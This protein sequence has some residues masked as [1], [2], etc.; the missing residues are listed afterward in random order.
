MLRTHLL[1]VTLAAALAVAAAGCKTAAPTTGTPQ[2]GAQAG[3]GAPAGNGAAPARSAAEAGRLQASAA[4]TAAAMGEEREMDTYEA[5]ADEAAAAAYALAYVGAP[6]P[7]PG[8][9]VATAIGKGGK[10]GAGTGPAARVVV[11]RPVP[12]KQLDARAELQAALKAKLDA[13]RTRLTQR[14]HGRVAELQERAV[15]AGAFG[16]NGWV[17][18]EAAGTETRTASFEVS[19][20]VNG[21]AVSRAVSMTCTRRSAD[22]VLLSSVVTFKNAFAGGGSRESTRTRALQDDGSTL[23]TYAS[24]QTFKDGT[25]RVVDF[26]RT[27]SADGAVAGGGT[28]T[29]TRPGGAP[30]VTN[31]SFGGSEEA[32]TATA[33][34]EGGDASATV[35]VPAD[36]A[37]T[38]TTSDGG[39][40]PVADAAESGEAP[41]ASGAEPASGGDP[42]PEASAS[43]AAAASDD[44]GA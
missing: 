40:V 8:Q 34:P 44:A 36:G 25:T 18:D 11:K 14:L 33:Q 35:S 6:S 42:A 10:P 13:R 32:P 21:Q 27:V 3:T 12:G 24:S 39:T 19:K 37:A 31:V 22:K 15:I 5:A 26:A 7:E 29:V 2:T 4:D 23:V 17:A 43:P 38:A 20:T 1:G 30:Q 9:L 16:K 28:I 41:P